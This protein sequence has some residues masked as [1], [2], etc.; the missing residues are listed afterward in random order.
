M[1]FP[2]GLLLLRA[3]YDCCDSASLFCSHWRGDHNKPTEMLLE[4]STNKSR[5]KAAIPNLTFHVFACTL[6]F[7]QT[8]P[9]TEKFSCGQ[10]LHFEPAPIFP[11]A[12]AIRT[13]QISSYHNAVVKAASA[14]LYSLYMGAAC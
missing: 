1:S 6:F 11:Q 5:E 3:L 9:Q 2:T 8:L 10:P 13:I 12:Q 7:F 4:P 14:L